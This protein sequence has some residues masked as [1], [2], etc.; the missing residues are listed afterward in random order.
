MF[1]AVTRAAAADELNGTIV[2]GRVQEIVQL[3]ALSFGLEIYA[4]HVRGCPSVHMPAQSKTQFRMR[5]EIE[6]V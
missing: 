4:Q 6:E 2:R 1:D 5:M 3:D